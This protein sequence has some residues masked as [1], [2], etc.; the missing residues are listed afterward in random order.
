[1]KTVALKLLLAGILVAVLIS[2]ANA[3]VWRI[4]P[5]GLGDAAT[6]QA[7]VDAAVAG[8]SVVLTAGTYTGVGNRDVSFMGKAITVTSY[9]GAASTIIDCG[10]FGRAFAFQNAEYNTSVLSHVTIQ[11]GFAALGGAVYCSDAA[12]TIEHC[13]FIH[14]NGA[15]GAAIHMSG[16]PLPWEPTIRS[17]RFE[18][19]EAEY[20]G[21][22]LHVE[23]LFALYVYDSEFINNDGGLRGGAIES[24]SSTV[25]LTNCTLN[26]NYVEEQGGAVFC[27]SGTV[28]VWNCT[29]DGNGGP[30]V[31]GGAF[32]CDG[33][34]IDTRGGVLSNNTGVNG[35]AV[36]GKQSSV[37]LQVF[38]IEN[39]SAENGG[40]VYLDGGNLLVMESRFEGN[41]ANGTHGNRSGGAVHSANAG[42]D[43]EYSEFTSNYAQEGGAVFVSGGFGAYFIDNSFTGNGGPTNYAGGAIV[44]YN[45][46]STIE[47]NTF[48]GNESS[49]G[50]AIKC[51]GPS[52]GMRNNT[53]DSNRGRDWGGAVYCSG[54][55]GDISFNTFT[56][57]AGGW[58]GGI[59][60]NATQ[61]EIHDNTFENNS[62][63]GGGIYCEVTYP[64]VEIR[65]NT[66]VGNS[67]SGIICEWGGS[68]TIIQNTFHNNS[69]SR[70]GAIL[71][72]WDA[73]PH[74]IHN[75][76][77]ENTATYGGGVA[78]GFDAHPVLE[79]N[80]IYLNSANYGGGVSCEWDSRPQVKNNTLSENSATVTGGNF[81]SEGASPLL[82]NNIIAFSGAGEGVACAEESYGVPTFVCC[83]VYGNAGGDALC[84]NDGGGNISLDPDFCGALGSHDYTLAVASP[85]APT[86]N[87]CG[88]LIGAL[89]AACR[90]DYAQEC[91]ADLHVPPFSTVQSISMVGFRIKN[92]ASIPATFSYNVTAEGPATLVDK[93]NPLALAG[94][95]PLLDPG[96]TFYPPEAALLIPAINE[97]VQQTVTYNVDADGYTQSLNS[98]ETVLTIEPPVA[99]TI[100]DFTADAVDVGVALEWDVEADEAFNGFALF[101]S[102][103]RADPSEAIQVGGLIA[104]DARRYVDNS[105]EPGR[106]YFYVL[107]VEYA[108]GV[109]TL[110]DRIEVKTRSYATGLT[111]NYPNPFNPSTRI[112]YTLERPAQVT[113][114]IYDVSGRRVRT[115][116]DRVDGAGRH[117]R[118][119]D[120]RDDT[121]NE[122]ASGVY[123]IRLTVAE[124]AFT[125]RAVLLR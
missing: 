54:P 32:Y 51:F 11:N 125:T 69:G 7:G 43:I 106:T 123:F 12:P 20:S 114:T 103:D 36:Y 93:G 48:V 4:Q 77:Y 71:C 16:F 6:I 28:F 108:D 56:G 115:L 57:N 116:V 5:D 70:G 52:L 122:V 18:E 35:G 75:D 38:D 91:P 99:V 41:V 21:G 113:L 112:P 79:D 94:T 97:Y 29:L 2:S 62:G 39:N 24:I 25:D 111:Q 61:M 8:D 83:D 92:E 81:Y 55:T 64:A 107:H 60:L 26:G 82:E 85:C 49:E 87:T 37:W 101:R 22:G 118:E 9:S 119:W 42:V 27:I 88:V 14:N 65:S 50:G 98:C 40:G 58:G 89:P 76:I 120:G 109:Q 23:D 100:A 117:E 86:N 15:W 30:G 95:T 67:G 53:F 31:D 110:S 63:Y 34:S 73:D 66:F 124:R 1:M 105:V 59:Y 46:T 104:A 102:G 33:G 17:C 74:V 19:N 10:G 80:L 68:P 3:R 121:G 78:I 45:T 84:G 13:V 47:N 90:L 44:A 96:A 72:G